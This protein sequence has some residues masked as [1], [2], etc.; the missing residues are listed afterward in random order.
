MSGHKPVG[1]DFHPRQD[2]LY[3]AVKVFV[4]DASLLLYF[5][6]ITEDLFSCNAGAF[7]VPGDLADND[8]CKGNE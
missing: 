1:V 5:G 2:F 8:F 3:I 4:G 7:V 6:E